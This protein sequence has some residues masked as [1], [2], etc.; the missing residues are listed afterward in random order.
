MGNRLVISYADF[1]NN[2]YFVRDDV[3]WYFYQNGA[4]KNYL[5]NRDRINGAFYAV[6]LP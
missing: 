1:L 3:E 6:R 5:V 2:K 4:G